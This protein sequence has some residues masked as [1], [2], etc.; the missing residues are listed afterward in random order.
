MTFENIE[1][2]R[3]ISQLSNFSFSHNVFN[4]TKYLFFQLYKF[5]N[6][7][8]LLIFK[9]IC[10]RFTLYGKGLIIYLICHFDPFP[11]TAN[12][13]QS[14]VKTSRQNYFKNQPLGCVWLIWSLDYY[15]ISN[16]LKYP[17]RKGL[18][19]WTFRSEGEHSS[20]LLQKL[21]L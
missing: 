4:S 6:V 18:E 7:F 5:N 9:F 16:S 8:C 17:T 2:K 15:F 21:A 13:W 1:A 11:H 12:L 14:N 20:T 19:P 3:D 10:L